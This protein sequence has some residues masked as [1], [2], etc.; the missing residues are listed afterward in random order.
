MNFT[1]PT[2]QIQSPNFPL[3][4]PAGSN[5]TYYINVPNATALRLTFAAFRLEN[6]HDYLQYYTEQTANEGFRST[7][8][9][10]GQ[11]APL[12]V[13][14][15]KLWLRFISDESIEYSGFRLSYEASCKYAMDWYIIIIIFSITGLGKRLKWLYY[16]MWSDQIEWVRSW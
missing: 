8:T 7:L 15:N 1:N 11:E 5:C 16:V 10:L 9:G 14:S 3:R 4:Y 12:E 2:G 13:Y 6:N